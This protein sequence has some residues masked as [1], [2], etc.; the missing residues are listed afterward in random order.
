MLENIYSMQMTLIRVTDEHRR[1]AARFV[2][3]LSAS[4]P[5]PATHEI[6]NLYRSG[7]AAST[8]GAYGFTA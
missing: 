1:V 2:A 7:L 8:T 4:T 3:S 5:K 6:N